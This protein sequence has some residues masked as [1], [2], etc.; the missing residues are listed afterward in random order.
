MIFTDNVHDAFLGRTSGLEYDNA[1]MYAGTLKEPAKGETRKDILPGMVMKHLGNNVFTL[2][3]G[4]GTPFGLS[5]LF[6]APGFGKGGINQLGYANEF[7]VV[8]GN[9]NSTVYIKKEALDPNA[10]FALNATGAAV[11]VYA[12]ADG[13]IS[14]TGTA[15]VG[16][17]LEVHDNG[18][19]KIQLADPAKA[20]A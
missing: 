19:I 17:L 8:V 9:N 10:T 1:I 18:T 16:H 12:N 6:V 3:D 20:E 4:T 15:V 14:N 5:A 2:Y 7:T 11:P 13:R